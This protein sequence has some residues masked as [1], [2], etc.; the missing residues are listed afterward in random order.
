MSK[1]YAVNTRTLEEAKKLMKL[2][3]RVGWKWNSG[4][5]IKESNTYWDNYKEDTSYL[6]QDDFLYSHV[7]YHESQGYE[8]ITLAEAEQKL[9]EMFPEKF[10]YVE[11]E[12][13]GKEQDRLDYAKE[14]EID[15]SKIKDGDNVWIEVVVI[16]RDG[17]CSFLG[18]GSEDEMFFHN[19]DIIK[20]IPQ[21]TIEIDGKTYLK[22]DIKNN[23]KEI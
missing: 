21:Q 19:K 15:T 13:K 2:Y 6:F 8:T 17:A 11:T 12:S 9:R 23:C 7:E 20:H 5:K 4:R 22:E 1:K 10:E 18:R 16:R 3:E 14:Q